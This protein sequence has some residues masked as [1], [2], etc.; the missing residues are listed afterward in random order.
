MFFRSSRRLPISKEVRSIAQSYR[1]VSEILTILCVR[2]EQRQ[3][4]KMKPILPLSLQ[5]FSWQILNLLKVATKSNKSSDFSSV[6]FLSSSNTRSSSSLSSLSSRRI[7]PL[8]SDSLSYIVPL[9]PRKLPSIAT[10]TLS[11]HYST[12]SLLRKNSLK[13]T[14]LNSSNSSNLRSV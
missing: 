5:S 6:Q 8:E 3:T 10:P 13:F 7:L 11:L 2:A 12:P 9:A 14:L 1:R 4:K